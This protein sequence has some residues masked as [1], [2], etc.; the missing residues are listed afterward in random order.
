M[1]K[2]MWRDWSVGRWHVL[3]RLVTSDFLPRWP[4]ESG[5]GI[6]LLAHTGTLFQPPSFHTAQG[7]VWSVCIILHADS[8]SLS[9]GSMP[10]RVEILYVRGRENVEVRS[11]ETVRGKDKGNWVSEKIDPFPLVAVSP[12]ETVH[13][14]K[15]RMIHTTLA[16]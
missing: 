16:N 1:K 2:E 3:A 13:P 4:G 7:E 15:F 11:T 5:N 6:P 9:R 14:D 12:K 8:C 10:L